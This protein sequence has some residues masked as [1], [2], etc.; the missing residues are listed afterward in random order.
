MTASIGTPL[1]FSQGSTTVT[2]QLQV[3]PV[4]LSAPATREMQSHSHNLAISQAVSDLSLHSRYLDHSLVIDLIEDTS[5]VDADVLAEVLKTAGLKEAS[6]ID[7]LLEG[8]F[9][10]LS[11]KRDITSA[12]DAVSHGFLYQPWAK[13]ALQSAISQFIPFEEMLLVMGLHPTNAFSESLL[14]ELTLSANLMTISQMERARLLCLSRGLTL[15]QALVQLGLINIATYKLLIDLAARHRSGHISQVQLKNMVL[16]SFAGFNSTNQWLKLS[17]TVRGFGVYCS[18]PGLVEVLD[19]LVEA[20]LLTEVTILGVM[21]SALERSV[22]FEQV[23]NECSMIEPALLTLAAKL[24]KR[25]AMGETLSI[26]ACQILRER[27][28]LLQG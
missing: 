15:G 26:N 14:A 1:T 7:V 19:L 5:L 13:Q 11:D 24:Q 25:V 16:N 10:A 9:I 27:S 6:L 4:S 28:Q 12:Y 23:A 2:E 3:A 20:E 21:E 18:N 17:Q 22:S 8:G